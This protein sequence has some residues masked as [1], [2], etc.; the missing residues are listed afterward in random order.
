VKPEAEKGLIVRILEEMSSKAS[1]GAFAV[2]YFVD[3]DDTFIKHGD[4]RRIL[5]RAQA[6]AVVE[7]DQQA[8][9]QQQLGKV[10]VTQQTRGAKLIL[11][12]GP[13]GFVDYWAGR[14]R[15]EDG[16][17]VQGPLG[18]ALGEMDLKGWKAWKL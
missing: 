3:E 13:E 6:K 5:T 8:K 7:A 9:L 1:P 12:S 11:V 14:K 2:E 16:K 15:L 10:E 17:E 18:G 4:I